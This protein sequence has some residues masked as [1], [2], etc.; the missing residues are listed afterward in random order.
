MFN[1]KASLPSSF[2][3][4]TPSKLCYSGLGGPASAPR[5]SLLSNQVC[6]GRETKNMYVQV[7]Y[8]TRENIVYTGCNSMM[9]KKT[10]TYHFMEKGINTEV[11]WTLVR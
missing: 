1:G 4:L 7:S 8:K 3:R 10:S 11:G 9:Q 6:T 5:A 2:R